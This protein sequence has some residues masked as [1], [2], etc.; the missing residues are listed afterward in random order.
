MSPIASRVRCLAAAACLGAALLASAAGAQQV[1]KDLWA[2]N[3]VV[4]SMAIA[5]NTL[6]LGGSFTKVG[7]VIVGTATIDETTGAPL[8]GC[9]VVGSAGGPGAV[10]ALALDGSGGWYIGGEF[11]SVDGQPRNRL[12][13]LDAAGH[14]LP[15]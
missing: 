10:Y 2:P 9:P 8:P 5:S 7:P 11:T 6:Y 3:G 15:W 13:H 12:A 1:R 4:Y 14:L